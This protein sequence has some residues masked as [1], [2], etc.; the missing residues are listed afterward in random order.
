MTDKEFVNLN[1][2]KLKL[3][4]KLNSATGENGFNVYRGITMIG[5]IKMEDENLYW[6]MIR[7]I[8]ELDMVKILES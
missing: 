2:P 8:M 3:R 5:W 7:K 6:S 1:D 4:R